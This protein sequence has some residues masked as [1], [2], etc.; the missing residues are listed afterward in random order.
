MRT[1]SDVSSSDAVP[2]TALL[3]LAAGGVTVAAC[4]GVDRES[5]AVGTGGLPS[6]ITMRSIKP[7]A[8]DLVSERAATTFVIDAER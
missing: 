2:R 4:A 5:T 8:P 1:N 3:L 6:A 7:G